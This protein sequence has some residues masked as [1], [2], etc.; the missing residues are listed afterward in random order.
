MTHR[1]YY[2][3]EIDLNVQN[4]SR[5]DWWP[6]LLTLLPCSFTHAFL[7][8]EDFDKDC[9]VPRARRK[10]K[11]ARGRRQESVQTSRRRVIEVVDSMK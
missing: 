3:P 2:A 5:P 8:L 7:L 11:V 10:E 4:E 9:K 6:G 1:R